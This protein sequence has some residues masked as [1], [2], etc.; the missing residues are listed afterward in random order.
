VEIH[1]LLMFCGSQV[2]HHR[3]T[4]P[5]CELLAKLPGT[6]NSKG[7]AQWLVEFFP[8]SVAKGVVKVFGEKHE[9]WIEFT[10]NID[11]SLANAD[12]TPFYEFH[13]ASDVSAKPTNFKVELDK[14]LAKA[15]LDSS[16]EG[17]SD[18][19]T[20]YKALPKDRQDAIEKRVSTLKKAKETKESKVV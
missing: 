5:V 2:L 4:T 14:L 12:A 7:I 18:L 6:I 17:A 8:V 9:S 3:N 13:T 10:S 20:L 15:M 16:A 19:V 1:E 11:V